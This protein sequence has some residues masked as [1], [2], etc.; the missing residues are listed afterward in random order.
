MGKPPLRSMAPPPWI[1]E[2]GSICVKKV[3]VILILETY[4]H[5]I[6]KKYK[7]SQPKEILPL[8]ECGLSGFAKEN[9]SHY[10]LLNIELLFKWMYVHE[11]YGLTYSFLKHMELEQNPFKFGVCCDLI[12]HTLSRATTVHILHSWAVQHQGVSCCSV[13]GR[14]PDY[15]EAGEK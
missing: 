8:L 14:S 15:P 12:V 3:S 4:T 11:Q 10:Y 7:V 13:L 1:L 6:A 2:S 9:K 5:S